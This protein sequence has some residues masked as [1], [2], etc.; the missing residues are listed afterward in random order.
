MIIHNY[1]TGGGRLSRSRLDNSL[2][3]TE[4]ADASEN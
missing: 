2:V 4:V 1:N 3:D